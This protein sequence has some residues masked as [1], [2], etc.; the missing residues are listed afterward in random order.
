MESVI[1]QLQGFL[2]YLSD[3]LSYVGVCKVKSPQGVLFCGFPGTGK[4]FFT[5]A[6]AK[7]A[8]RQVGFYETNATEFVSQT[9]VGD[10]PR[11]V[12]KLFEDVRLH[13]KKEGV[14]ASIIFI[15][16]CEEAFKD[17]NKTANSSSDLP[18]VVN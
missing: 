11:F 12:K 8:G 3:P 4:T 7:E 5:R 18:N 15:D 16:E 17:L 13:N 1:D 9:L 10:G 14:K 2:N 6:L